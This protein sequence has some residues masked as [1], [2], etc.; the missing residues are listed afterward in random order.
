[1]SMTKTEVQRLQKLE[2]LRESQPWLDDA[3][4]EEYEHLRTLKY[5]IDQYSELESR[6]KF[7]LAMLDEDRNELEYLRTLPR[8]QAMILAGEAKAQKAQ[9]AKM[10]CPTHP[11]E[12]S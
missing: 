6:D 12:M 9:K 4:D 7:G 8:I 11:G 1:M 3:Q 10:N 2:K 5:Q